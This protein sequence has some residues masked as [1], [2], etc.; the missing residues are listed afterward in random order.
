MFGL[1]KSVVATIFLFLFL[2][3]A[4][5]WVRSYFVCELWQRSL[6]TNENLAFSKEIVGFA[7]GRGG[8]YLIGA[9][10]TWAEANKKLADDQ[11][12]QIKNGW[13]KT[14][15]ANPAYGGGFFKHGTWAGFG[16]SS[17]NESNNI[18]TVASTSMVIPWACPTI[19]LG[20]MSWGLIN[21]C[22]AQ[23]RQR[24][25]VQSMEFADNNYLRPKEAA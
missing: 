13:A 23:R 16:F 11:V 6:T 2:V 5:L 12:K 15:P 14:V 8:I 25:F 10:T 21:H 7:S 18:S 17:T 9:H 19:V 20:L 1:I 22:R 4:T 24:R 3:L